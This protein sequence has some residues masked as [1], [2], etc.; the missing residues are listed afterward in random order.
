MATPEQAAATG[1]PTTDAFVRSVRRSGLLDESQLE[2]LVQ[3]VPAD[4]RGD[5][6]LL[7]DHLVKLGKLSR[8]QAGKLLEGITLGLVLGPYHVLSPI[9]K[10]GMGAVYLARDSRN[11]SLVA[12]KVL[13]P[14]RAKASERLL[15]RFR[16]EMELNQRVNHPHLTRTVEVGVHNDVNYIAMEFIPGRNLYKL[17]HGEGPLA[18]P[19]AARL[20][21][22]VSLGLEYAHNMGLIHR[23]LKPSNIMVLPDDHIKVLDLGLALI[24][25]EAEAD[26]TIV[27]GQGYVVGTMDYLAPEQ[28]EDP[29]KVDARSDIYSLGCTLYFVLTGQT[30][31]PGGTALQKMLRHRCDP[32][33]PVNELNPSIPPRFAALLTRMIAKRPDF[34]FQNCVELR[35]ALKP[36]LEGE[37]PRPAAVAKAQPVETPAPEAAVKPAEPPPAPKPAPVELPPTILMPPLHPPAAVPPKPAPA[38]SPAATAAPAQTPRSAA[39]ALADFARQKPAPAAVPQAG[40]STKPAMAAMTLPKVA[41]PTAPVAV[42]V[43]PAPPTPAR[44]P[45]PPPPPAVAQPPAAPAPIV[46][47]KKPAQPAGEASGTVDPPTAGTAASATATDEL[48]FWLD[49]GLPVG[50]SAL[51]VGI[52]WT[53]C[54]ILI[55]RQ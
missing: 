12:L 50:G 32:P 21:T 4:T 33:K 22:E 28:G 55:W 13:P 47:E 2:S 19:R 20:F 8:F 15:A 25:G 51:L 31:F 16:R 9:G 49:F 41:A 43:S 1:Q 48:P 52:L 26:R 44:P 34:R 39:A 11:Q 36:W 38:A 7:A 46:V 5:A 45:E 3:A 6:K 23:D 54:M 10:G 35:E 40:A 42:L 24:Q 53:L 18:I 37:A 17:V 14:K 27:G 29:L 30:P